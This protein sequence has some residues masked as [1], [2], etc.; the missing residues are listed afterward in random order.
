V[1]TEPEGP[2]WRFRL[3]ATASLAAIWLGL[4]G[5]EVR[6]LVI[7]APVVALAVLAAERTGGARYLPLLRPLPGFLW[8][9][10]V[11]IARSAWDMA[12][13][14]LARDPGFAPALVAYPLRLRGEGALAAF[15]NAVTLTPGTLSAGLTDDRL[16]VHALD[17][18]AETDDALRALEARVARLYGETLP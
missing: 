9:T 7:G 4:T 6:A 2:R 17:P 13:R 3:L 1:L 11:E 16:A 15:M 8:R 12:R 5:G 14:I 18:G 10:G